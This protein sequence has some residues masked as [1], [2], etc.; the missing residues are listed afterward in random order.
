MQLSAYL[1]QKPLTSFALAVIVVGGVLFIALP[2]IAPAHAYPL[3]P[4]D[5]IVSWNWKGAYQD[6]GADEQKTQAE[7]QRLSGQLGN[8][9]DY[10]LYVG[11]A[12]EYELLG[13]GHRVY[14]YLSRAIAK[15]GKRGLAYMNMG[16]LMEILGAFRTA[17]N[18][19]DAAIA[20]E[21]GNPLYV[22]ARTDFVARHPNNQ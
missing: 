7:I 4:G 20:A 10:E 6:G 5:S 17:R 16:H 2:L 18:A 3:A 8:G 15:D 19:F 13:E 22:S 21:P 9:K 14:E 11:I 1:R 12:S